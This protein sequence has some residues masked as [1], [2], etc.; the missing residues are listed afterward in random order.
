MPGRHRGEGVFVLLDLAAHEQ[1]GQGEV[2]QDVFGGVNLKIARRQRRK[3]GLYFFLADGR[4][5]QA[6]DFVGE[7]LALLL[8]HA[9]ERRAARE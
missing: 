3:V 2:G 6:A 9:D 4:G 7:Q 5:Q 8:L 1:V